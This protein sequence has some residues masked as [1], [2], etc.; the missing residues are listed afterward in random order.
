MVTTLAESGVYFWRGHSK[1]KVC[2]SVQ[3][4]MSQFSLENLDSSERVELIR[5]VTESLDRNDDYDSIVEQLIAGG[6]PEI[7][8]H[9]FV[10]ALESQRHV[11]AHNSEP[12]GESESQ[13]SAWQIWG[14]ISI[15]IA[16]LKWLLK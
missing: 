9:E 5:L 3:L 11:E 4:S 15:V 8:A 6:F 7:E 12:L 1:F 10:I 16:I 13:L 2:K 14:L